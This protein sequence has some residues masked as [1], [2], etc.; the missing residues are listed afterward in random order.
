VIGGKPDTPVRGATRDAAL[1]AIVE[2]GVEESRA[3]YGQKVGR[4]GICNRHLT[5]KLSRDRGIGPDCWA[6]LS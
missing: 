1:S 5:D 6:K 4:C 2:M 3:R